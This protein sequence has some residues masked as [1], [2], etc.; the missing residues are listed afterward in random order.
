MYL[1]LLL[2]VC[3]FLLFK[4]IP[5]YGVVV[6]FKDY[7]IFKGVLGSS[8]IGFDAFKQ[9]FA[10]KEFYRALKNTFMLNAL[11]L[12]VSFPAPIILALL[13]NEVRAKWF[14][15]T[16]QTLLYVP[17]FISWVIISGMIY[18]IAANQ[19]IINNV[20]DLL[21]ISPIPILTNN[22]NWVLTYVMSGAWQSVGWGT[23]IYLAALTGINPDLYEAAGV[24]GAGRWR[25]MWSITIPGMIPTIMILLVINIGHMASI[26]LERPFTLGNMMVV[27]VSD[28]IST[29]V[30]RVGIQ[31]ANF[32]IAT[33]VGLFQGL[34][35]M[36]FLVAAN[37]I[38]KKMTEQGL[39]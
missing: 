27:N 21:G 1:L 5:M 2:P 23:I 17:H 4:Y 26:G 28:V 7:N 32:T 10:M 15:R 19:G 34:V 16:S 36:I 20:L 30:Y 22:T 18:R 35:S 25:K 8:W 31:S 6:A 39:W 12:I 3:Y 13:L 37:A 29:F 14:K 24:D 11:D 9:V 33:A 38:S